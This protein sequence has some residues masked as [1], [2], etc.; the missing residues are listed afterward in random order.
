MWTD[1]LKYNIKAMVYDDLICLQK[2]PIQA[3]VGPIWALNAYPIF[4]YIF[5][6]KT[7]S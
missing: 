7:S 4:L 3:G 1:G 6:L 5:F 2:W